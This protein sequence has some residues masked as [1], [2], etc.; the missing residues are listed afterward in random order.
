MNLPENVDILYS[1]LNMKLRDKYINIEALCD[2]MEVDQA[3]L[4]TQMSQAQY[5]YNRERNQFE[6]F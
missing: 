4:L 6:P 1:F 2:D 3:Q 5:S